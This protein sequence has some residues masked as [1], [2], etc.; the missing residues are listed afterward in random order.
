MIV[1]AIPAFNEEKTIAKIVVRAMKQVDRVVVVDDG[2]T[3]DTAM[4]AERLGAYVIRHEENKGYGAAIRSCFSAAKD[5]AADVLVTLD[6]DGQ[7]DAEQIPEVIEPILNGEA[8]VVIGSRFHEGSES[9][10]P[11][12]RLAGMRMLNEATKRISRQGITDSQSGFRAYSRKAIDSIRI[13]ETGM[14]VTSEIGIRTNEAGLRITE[15]PIRV[16]YSGLKSS[17]QNP[18]MHGLEVISALLR[19]AGERHPVLLF[20]LPGLLSILGGLGGWLWTANRF[21]EIQQLP[22]GTALLSTIL[23]IAGIV[24]V[25]TAIILYTIANVSRRL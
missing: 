4:I 7:H 22:L 25:N 10:I 15:V 2:S 3:D 16:E 24:A 18:L 9:Q 17:S 12:Y 20:G 1:A 19:I 13:Y 6:G 23:L 5:L 21:A 8:E 14:G 11:R